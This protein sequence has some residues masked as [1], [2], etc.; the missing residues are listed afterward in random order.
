M[1][2]LLTLPLLLL[3]SMVLGQNANQSGERPDVTI[4]GQI[5]EKDLNVPLEY[6]TVA[7]ID[8]EGKIITGGITDSKGNYSILVPTGVYTVQFEFISYKR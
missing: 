7:F 2:L 8:P 6:A 1:K 4:T 3:F 5:I